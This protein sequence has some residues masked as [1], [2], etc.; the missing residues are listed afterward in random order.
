M[1]IYYYTG[2]LFNTINVKYVK[3]IIINIK[4]I[5]K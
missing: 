2:V 3:L 1:D 4:E 5:A